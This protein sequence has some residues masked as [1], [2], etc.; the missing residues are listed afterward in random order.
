MGVTDLLP[1]VTLCVRPIFCRLY[2]VSFQISD[3]VVE[4]IFLNLSA[5]FIQ[6]RG[7]VYYH[8]EELKGIRGAVASTFD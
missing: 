4:L 8:S 6:N 7:F 5:N 1:N 3:N 2:S